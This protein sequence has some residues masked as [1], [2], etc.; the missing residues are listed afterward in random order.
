[1]RW[2]RHVAY[3][4]VTRNAYKTS[5]G[6]AERKKSL[7]R[8]WHKWEHIKVNLRKIWF[9]NVDW[10]HLAQTGTSVR[11]CIHSDEPSGSV[12]DEEFLDQLD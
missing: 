7:G 10:N 1:M 11:S 3:T 8:P 9:E 6:K 5:L 4:Q 12:Q 2:V